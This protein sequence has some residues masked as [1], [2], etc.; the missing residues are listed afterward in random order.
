M[1]PLAALLL[2]CTLAAP[3]PSGAAD[4]KASKLQVEVC[5]VLDTTGSMSGL[6]EGAKQKIWSIANQM[7]SAKP[8]PNLKV[9]LV[10]YRDRGDEYVTRVFDLS[11]DI[12]AVYGNLRG[13]KAD[14]GG[15]TPESVNEALDD[16]VR[17]VSWSQDRNTLKVIFLVGDAPPHMD[18]K[19]GPR[20][21]DVC[22]EAVKRDLVINTVQCGAI[23][24]TGPVWQ[25]IARLSEGTFSAI[26]QTGSMVAIATPMDAEIAEL[27][28]KVGETLIAYGAAGP[29]VR[30]KQLVAESAAAPAVADR[31]AFNAR[32]GRSVQGDG[33]LIDAINDGR[34]KLE[35]MDRKDLPAELRDLA[36]EALKSRVEEQQAKR[37]ALQKQINE[38]NVRREAYIAGEKK[39]LSAVGHTDSFDEKVAETIRAQAARKGITYA[40]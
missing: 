37:A 23:A 12:D 15:D 19:G 35:S 13:F 25:Q 16:A 24:E 36:P 17:K 33:E 32:T 34:V 22:Q 9:A 38:A 1:K 10:A 40:P 11:D 2:A 3:T 7:I 39:R 29:S 27:N 28:R 26:S 5:F 30:A 31:L 18:Y 14:G 4:K 8:T 20:Y 6:I 21:T